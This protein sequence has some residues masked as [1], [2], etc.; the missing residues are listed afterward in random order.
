MGYRKQKIQ[1]TTI[2]DGFQSM[3]QW[4]CQVQNAYEGRALTMAVMLCNFHAAENGQ[5]QLA[6]IVKM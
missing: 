5:K 4:I 1:P 3:L 6:Y 2:N